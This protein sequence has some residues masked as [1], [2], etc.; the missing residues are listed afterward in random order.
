MSAVKTNFVPPENGFGFVNAFKLKLPVKFKIPLAGEVDLSK[1]VVGF[2]GGMCFSA[3]DYYYAGQG[4]PPDT[5]VDLIDQKLYSYLAGRQLDSIPPTTLIKVIEWMLREKDDLGQRMA[6]TEIP[7]LR[8]MLDKGQPAVLLLV[9][10]AGWDDPTR[11][12]QV[13]ATGYELDATG[14]QMTI[15]LY[16]PNHPKAESALK[17]DLSDPRSGID[18]TQSNDVPTRAFFI[19]NYKTE[20]A[21][22]VLEGPA[23]APA[24]ARRRPRAFGVSAAAPAISLRWPVDSFRINQHFGEN[25]QAYK[26]FKL[27][28]HEGLDFFAPDGAN[29][30]AA[31]DGVV[32]QAGHPDNHPYG[33]HIRIRHKNGSQTYH[34]V[35]AHLSRALV[36]VNQKVTAGEVI[37]L[38]DNTGNS[39]GSHLH[40]T[41]K[42]DG[43]TTSGYPAGIVDPLPYFQPGGGPGQKPAGGTIQPPAGPGKP[44]LPPASGITV[45]TNAQLELHAEPNETSAKT[46]LVPSGE[47]L[48]V[49]GD[50]AK[51]KDL[52]GK[53]GQWLF[54]QTA[55]GAIG[56][57]PAG[58]VSS[59]MQVFPPSSL[60]VYPIDLVNLRSGPSTAFALLGSLDANQALTV[61]GDEGLARAKLGRMNEWLMVQTADGQKA[62]VAAW[63]VHL[64]GQV[65]PAARGVEVIPLA[66]VNL[67]ARPVL[68][69]NSLVVVTP[70]DRLAVFGDKAQILKN[71]GLSDRWLNVRSPG[72]IIGFV[73]ADQVK[74][75]NEEQPPSP[76]P[77]AQ[78]AAGLQ[79]FATADLNIRAQPSLNSPRL[80]GA[81]RAQTLQVIEPDLDAARPKIGKTGQW[82]FVQDAQGSR[83]WA[84]AWFLSATPV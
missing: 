53:Q 43:Q 77:P 58:M 52:I 63:L 9:R 18:I 13:L 69:S 5:K 27:P 11:N 21:L 25:P 56:N 20:K 70:D 71:I 60:V 14:K 51:V 38:A 26:P 68:G 46:A 6:R 62:F 47:A 39:S 23:P 32:Y 42:I 82:L 49:L 61:L 30:Y 81:R 55:S 24:A 40:L 19:Q 84:A 79:V 57:V 41:L 3:L 45:Y 50:A 74:A 76:P 67:L 80:A 48:I 16:D 72:G 33:L 2:C 12:H 4:V 35:Y 36:Q 65:V 59:S 78:P 22:P 83:G 28:G 44:G 15:F 10:V 29:I 64:T 34:T 66:A 54:V 17:L 8:R 7:K 37:G 1:V 75:A 31:A 73:P